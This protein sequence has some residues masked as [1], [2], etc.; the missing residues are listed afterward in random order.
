MAKLPKRILD[1]VKAEFPLIFTRAYVEQNLGGLI[2]R[3]TLASFK[4]KPPPPS[5]DVNGKCVF[6]REE[7][8]KWFMTYYGVVDDGGS[9]ESSSTVQEPSSPEKGIRSTSKRSEK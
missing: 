1:L 3:S 2:S 6:Y 7:F 5:Y 8:F 9:E 4:G